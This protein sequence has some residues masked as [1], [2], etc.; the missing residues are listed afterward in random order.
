MIPLRFPPQVRCALRVIS[1]REYDEAARRTPHACPHVLSGDRRSGQQLLDDA[2]ADALRTVGR[3]AQ[4]RA[5]SAALNQIAA[6]LEARLSDVERAL[7]PNTGADDL[8]RPPWDQPW[9]PHA[10]ARPAVV[11][12]PSRPIAHG[13]GGIQLEGDGPA[14]A[15]M[16]SR[17]L[18]QPAARWAWNLGFDA[19]RLVSMIAGVPPRLAE[20]MR[21]LLAAKQ[22]AALAVTQRLA[23][24]SAAV[25][26][27]A[28]N[29]AGAGWVP[30][31][32][33]PEDEEGVWDDAA[34]AAMVLDPA[35]QR[36]ARLTCSAGLAR[37]W[38]QHREEILARFAMHEGSIPMSDLGGLC[39]LLA[40]A[41]RGADGGVALYQRFMFGQGS[42][43]RA[44]LV[45]ASK[46]REFDSLGRVRKVSVRPGEMQ[47]RV[48]GGL[49]REAW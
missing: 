30:P 47:S 13:W 35:T 26:P 49:Q 3:A 25:L 20:A 24:A 46:S 2:A 34:E 33:P 4:S 39:A 12:H 22:R 18:A 27:A 43:V 7:R 6:Y 28:P 11:L 36:R 16:A 41:V 15:F 1:S 8:W 29:D 10:E 17:R 19:A 38:G 40:D 42:A 31:H 48:T 23:V 21:R 45:C 37:L 5:S 32:L 14:L 44:V 9:R